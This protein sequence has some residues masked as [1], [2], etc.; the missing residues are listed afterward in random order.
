MSAASTGWRWRWAAA[1]QAA[2]R[3]RT[4][5]GTRRRRHLARPPRRQTRGSNTPGRRAPR[6]ERLA[7]LAMAVFVATGILALKPDLKY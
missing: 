3:R 4:T 5:L 6:S 1:A 7:S 2:L